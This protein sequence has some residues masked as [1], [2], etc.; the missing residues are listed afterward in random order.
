M[1]MDCVMLVTYHT[2]VLTVMVEVRRIKMVRAV[3]KEREA[4]ASVPTSP[5]SKNAPLKSSMSR[6]QTPRPEPQKTFGEKVSTALL[7]DKGSLLLNK[8][9]ES[10]GEKLKRRREEWEENPMARLKLL[11]VSFSLVLAECHITS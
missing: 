11:V 3:K 9:N 2:A 6:P 10:E 4:G 5:R 7:G 8:A 1:V